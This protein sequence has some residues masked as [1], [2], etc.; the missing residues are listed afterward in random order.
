MV[1]ALIISNGFLD[2][3]D[4]MQWRDGYIDELDT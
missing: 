4:G 1:Y 2:E 3:A